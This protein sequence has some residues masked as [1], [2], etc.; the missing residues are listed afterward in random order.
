MCVRLFKLLLKLI[1]RYGSEIW[2]KKI[3]HN[4]PLIEFIKLLFPNDGKLKK[5]CFLQMQTQI[6][7]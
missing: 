7:K 3:N 2:M 6:M 4:A 5:N 1:N